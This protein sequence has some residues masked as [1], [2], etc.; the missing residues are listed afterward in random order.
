MTKPTEAPEAPLAWAQASSISVHCPYCRQA[1]RH[2]RRNLP[3]EGRA[4][5][6]PQCG[7]QLNPAERVTGYWVTVP[8]KES[9]S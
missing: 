4:R 1:H 5:L 8:P 2:E 6:A 9:R 3:T 7:L